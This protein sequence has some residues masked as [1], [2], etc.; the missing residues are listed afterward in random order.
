MTTKQAI[1]I[2]GTSGNPGEITEAVKFLMQ[3]DYERTQLQN[4]CRALTSGMLCNYCEM[5][6]SCYKKGE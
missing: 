6:E 4:R 3:I 5:K 2:V 1:E